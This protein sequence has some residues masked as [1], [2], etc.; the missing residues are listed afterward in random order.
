LPP[1][2]RA[3]LLASIPGRLTILTYSL[4]PKEAC[5]VAHLLGIAPTRRSC[6]TLLPSLPP[7]GVRRRR[8]PL[9]PNRASTNPS[10]AHP[11]PR[12]PCTAG[13][14]A[15]L[16]RIGQAASPP[17]P[18]ATLQSPHLFLGC[19]LQTEGMVVTVSIFEGSSM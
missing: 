1:S 12:A 16:A 11:P 7:T 5:T 10:W 14:A 13:S 17:W 18:R 2:R 15:G 9:R 8:V 4:G 19:L 3:H 6:S